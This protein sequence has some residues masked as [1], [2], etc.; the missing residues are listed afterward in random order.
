M[1]IAWLQDLDPMTHPGGA[2]FND[3][4]K[5][6]AGIRRG[7]DIS[8]MLPPGDD[9]SFGQVDATIISNATTFTPDLFKAVR[10]AGKPYIFFIHDYWPLCKVRLYYPLQEKCRSCYRREDWLPILEGAAL[11]IWLSPLHKEAWGHGM[12][13][14]MD[15]QFLINPSTID[16]S[17]F[18]DMG[19]ERSGTIAV[20]SGMGFKGRDLFFEWAL[21]HPDESITLVGPIERPPQGGTVPPNISVLRTV[22]YSKMNELYNKHTTFLHIPENPMPFDRTIVEAQLAGCKVITNE[23]V[24]AM[25]WP[26]IANGDHEGIRT[27]MEKANGEFWDGVEGVIN[28]H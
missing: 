10:D 6:Q 9:N 1:K 18:W 17:A 3:K 22:H 7:H 27:L 28:E 15:I 5:I 25:S 8:I 4:E 14:L 12:P 20:D 26:A 2:Q 16:C 11:R 23:N 24:G 13:E 19:N 21:E